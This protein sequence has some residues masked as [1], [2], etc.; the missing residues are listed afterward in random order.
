MKEVA[1]KNDFGCRI[2]NACVV[3]SFIVPELRDDGGAESSS[4]LPMKAEDEHPSPLNF[5]R[6]KRP[7]RNAQLPPQFLVVVLETGH[8]VFLFLRPGSNGTFEFVESRFRSPGHRTGYPGFHVAVDP[9]SRYMAV[10]GAADHFVVYELES[11]AELSQ[12]YLDGEPLNPVRSF[13]MHSVRGVIHKMAFLHPRPGDQ[14]HIILLLIVV[15]NGKSRMVIYEW[16]LGDDLKTV[17]NRE[18]HGHRMPVEHQMPLLIIPLMLQSAF[19]T[20][21]V[22][23]VA[24][25]TGCLHGPPDF[26]R[27]T[28]QEAK[29]PTVNHRGRGQ[30]LWTAWARPFRLQ[31]YNRSRDCIYLA[32]EDGAV[33]FWDF[34]QDTF[35]RTTWLD[36]PC[37][38]SSAFA[39]LFDQCMDVLV[40]GSDSGPGGYWKV[41]KNKHSRVSKICA[42]ID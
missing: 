23:H 38:I 10:A 25:C 4:L 19:I 8:N 11:H 12:M 27:F 33:L 20:I 41:G 31:S 17:F 15:R 18:K 24:V 13:R 42:S 3:G 9:S 26:E 29:G 22:D 28:I 2:R 35:I 16:E 40:L 6:P 39:C 36:F 37:S 32:R 5:P 14:H 21:S 30:P 1:R 7:A 34:D